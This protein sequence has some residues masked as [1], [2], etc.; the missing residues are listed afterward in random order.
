[1]INSTDRAFMH[2][3]FKRINDADTARTIQVRS[4]QSMDYADYKE[5]CG[6]LRALDDVRDWCQEI[7]ESDDDSPKAGRT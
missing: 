2:R 3:L 7:A 1:M 5:R 6:Y 4:A